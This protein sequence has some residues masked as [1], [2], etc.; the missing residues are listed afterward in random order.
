MSHFGFGPDFLKWVRTLYFEANMRIILNGWL[1][2]RIFLRRGVRQGDPLSPLLY[3]LCIEV[4]AIQIRV[5]PH[6][7]CFLLPGACSYFKVRNNADDTTTFVRDLPLLSALF[8]VVSLYERGMGA[9]LNRSKT[10][11]MWVGAWKSWDDEAFGLT[12]VNKMKGLGVWFGTVPAEQDNW[13]PKINKFQKC[14]NSWKSRSL[15][16]VGKAMII[17]IIGLSKFFHL[18]SV[19]LLPDWVVRRVNQIIW[20]FLWGSQLETVVH[21]T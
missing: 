4:L 2:D 13:Q 12:W 14:I 19:L 6:I 20:P 17:N 11:A 16:L 10:E 1:M 8:D 5:D 18:A 3:V 15:S 21:N 7:K 9:K